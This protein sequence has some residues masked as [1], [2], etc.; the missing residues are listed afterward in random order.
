MFVLQ[1][2]LSNGWYQIL[3]TFHAT[4]MIK[5]LFSLYG[6][7]YRNVILCSNYRIP[8]FLNDCLLMSFIKMNFLCL[9]KKFSPVNQITMFK[10]ESNRKVISLLHRAY[11]RV[12]QL[13][14]QLLHIYKIYK[15]YTLKH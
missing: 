11:F 13:L 12:T 8:S 1:L 6:L 2:C 7:M 3:C 4:I 10:T 5:L 9:G 14:Y 15:I